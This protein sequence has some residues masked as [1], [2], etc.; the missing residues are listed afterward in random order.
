MQENFCWWIELG[1]HTLY[2]YI[3]LIEVTIEYFNYCLSS[4]FIIH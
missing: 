2:V 1:Y 3:H 4:A